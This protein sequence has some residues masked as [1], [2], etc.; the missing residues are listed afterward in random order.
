MTGILKVDTIQK[1]DGSVPTLSDLGIVDP[2][3]GLQSGKLLQTVVSNRVA[4]PLNVTS[5]S[6]VEL[7]TSMRITWTVQD[8]DSYVFFT[9]PLYTEVDGTTSHGM[10]QLQYSLNSG[11]SWST[12][13]TYN[14][15]G[16]IDNSVG[17]GFTDYWDHNLSV[18][19][20]VVFR[21]NY[22]I[23]GGAQNAIADTGPGESPRTYLMLQEVNL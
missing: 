23:G 2:T 16:A 7:S 10:A 17:F 13:G 20:S 22:R 1:N 9:C 14:I 15:T 21:V 19:Q 5:T 11:S 8:T 12:V 6:F 4:G 3:V 18:G